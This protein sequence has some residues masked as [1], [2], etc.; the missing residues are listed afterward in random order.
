MNFT[1]L[2]NAVYTETNR[3]DLV[4]ET[5]QKVLASALKLHCCDFFYKDIATTEAIFDAAAYIQTLDVSAFPR[6]RSL[7][8]FRKNDPS[9]STYQQNPT[10]LPPLY[11][12]SGQPSN[13][14]MGFFRVITPDD[15]LDE[16]L[17]EKFDVC[18]QAGQTLFFKSS[19][20]VQYGLVG[21]YQYPNLDYTLDAN[22]NPVD[23]INFDS[24]VAREFPHA[25]Y[26]D[27]ASAVLQTIGMTDAARKYDAPA[28][29][30]FDGGLATQAM[31][32]LIM[33]NIVAQGR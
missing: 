8:Y 4:A 31:K 15:I 16:F 23:S 14:S 10:I 29:N 33:N 18:Y 5:I 1:Q 17:Q 11:T 2:V 20:A 13:L 19:T 28:G 6:Y 26:Y 3:P 25:I 24:W 22:G 30:G 27:A 21:W 7:S 12:A 32:S 9:L